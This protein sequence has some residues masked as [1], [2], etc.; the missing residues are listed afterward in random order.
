MST[1]QQSPSKSALRTAMEARNAEAIVDAFAPDA[2]FHS[3]LTGKLAF[4]GREQIAAL[5]NIILDVLTDFRYTD[6]LLGENSGILVSR[7][8]VDGIDIEMVDHIRFG[9]DGKIQEFTVFMRPL[10]AATAALRL[11]GAGLGRRKSL[12]RAALISA[13]TSPLAFM[14]RTGDDIG[15]R[16][17]RSTL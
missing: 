8:K 17:I 14:T 7:A 15:V 11:I 6:E 4:K 5:T 3:P 13:L 2:V 16:L 12:A 1:L 10:P 9:S